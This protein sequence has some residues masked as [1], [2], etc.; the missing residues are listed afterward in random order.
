MVA[1]A[2]LARPAGPVGRALDTALG[3]VPGADGETVVE[4]MMSNRS[5]A[6]SRAFV[7]LLVIS[8]AGGLEVVESAGEPTTL[9][10]GATLKVALPARLGRLPHGTYYVSVVPSDPESGR[11]I[12]IGQYHVQM[13]L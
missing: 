8:D 13:K 2:A 1:L 9:E 7:P 6:P 12:G 4:A 10:A 5:P 3:D 11:S